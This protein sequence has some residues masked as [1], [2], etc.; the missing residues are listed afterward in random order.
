MR[1]LLYLRYVYALTV[2]IVMALC[3]ALL[4][5]SSRV[6]ASFTGPTYVLSRVGWMDPYHISA[7]LEASKHTDRLP[8]QY[9]A[10]KSSVLE[11]DFSLAALESRIQHS[12]RRP[13]RIS[14]DQDPWSSRTDLSQ[15]DPVD[16]PRWNVIHTRF[17]NLAL[18]QNAMNFNDKLQFIRPTKQF[19]FQYVYHGVEYTWIPKD[20]NVLTTMV[21]ETQGRVIAEVHVDVGAWKW[22]SIGRVVLSPLLDIRQHGLVLSMALALALMIREGNT[23]W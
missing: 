8:Q 9:I 2:A 13:G 15:Q 14:L 17:K 10:T 1:R 16:L 7:L 22:W 6:A 21:L 3:C 11:R 5:G 4:W 23:Q 20:K 12:P 18:I 19:S